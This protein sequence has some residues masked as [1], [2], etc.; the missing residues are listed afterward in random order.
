MNPCDEKERKNSPQDGV[1]CVGP[2]TDTKARILVLP[3]SSFEDNKDQF[4]T[5]KLKKTKEDSENESFHKKGKMVDRVM[6][7]DHEERTE[8]IDR[9]EWDREKT[10]CCITLFDPR[11]SGR[12]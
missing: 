10:A 12:I 9:T 8:S 1:R 2:V 5:D 4:S 6:E 7:Q 11:T 3:Q